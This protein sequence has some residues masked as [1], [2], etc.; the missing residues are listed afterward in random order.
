MTFAEK[1]RKAM[2][3]LGITQA[4]VVCM[5]GKSKGSISQ[6]LSGKQ[7]PPENA[8]RDLAVKLGLV[9]DYFEQ[10]EPILK[11]AK[12]GRGAIPEL[13]TKDAA[14]LM[15]MG[16]TTVEDGLKQGVFPWGYAIRKPS[17]Q[18]RYFINARRFAEHECV[19]IPP[20][21]VV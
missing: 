15:R 12:Q 10:D 13:R 1:M 8:Q 11:L 17:G 19:E 7:I 16:H 2:E 4:Q 18:Y 9:P 21:L 6:Y 5:T 14:K 20:E 3:D